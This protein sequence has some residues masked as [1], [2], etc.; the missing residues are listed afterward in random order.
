M[1]VNKNEYARGEAEAVLRSF[2]S[3]SATVTPSPS[4]VADSLASV[5]YAKRF[6]SA[7]SRAA[8]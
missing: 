5:P 7:I 2:L 3:L 8:A 4:A 6:E 1:S